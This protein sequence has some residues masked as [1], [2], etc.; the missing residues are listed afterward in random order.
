[1]QWNDDHLLRGVKLA[2]SHS[3]SNENIGSCG[4]EQCWQNQNCGQKQSKTQCCLQQVSC[5]VLLFRPTVVEDLCIEHRIKATAE[6]AA[7]AYVSTQR[8]PNG[9]YCGL[10]LHKIMLIILFVSWRKLNKGHFIIAFTH[11]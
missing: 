6:M 3:R 4:C 1:M 2:N 7:L 11:L 8:L 10:L 9:Q 5:L